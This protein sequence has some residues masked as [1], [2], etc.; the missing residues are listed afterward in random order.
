MFSALLLKPLVG[1]L[2][3]AGLGVLSQAI[4]GP[5]PNM[6]GEAVRTVL[7]VIGVTTPAEATKRI[8]VDPA[9]V[10]RLQTLDASPEMAEIAMAQEA[11]ASAL[12]AHEI[13]A[14]GFAYWWR[15]A[16]AWLVVWLWFQNCTVAI[17]FG[18]PQIP[19]SE[20]FAFSALFLSLYMGGHT[21]KSLA[22]R[23]LGGAAR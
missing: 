2:A 13:A 11:R 12:T 4:G 21:V 23:Y 5:L 3:K 22:D 19:W 6:A 7:D 18:L 9:I 8:A 17:F 10:E 16:G 15:P 1:A 20:L 14:G